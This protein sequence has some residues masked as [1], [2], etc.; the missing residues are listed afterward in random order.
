[1]FLYIYNLLW[2]VMDRAMGVIAMA[3]KR[4]AAVETALT[5]AQLTTPLTF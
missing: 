2:K 1:M 3:N 4:Q 5:T